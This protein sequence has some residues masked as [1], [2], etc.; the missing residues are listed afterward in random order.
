VSEP[1]CPFCV[2]PED[3]I[4]HRDDSV[5]GIWD[6]FPVSPGRALLVP[7][8]H[9]ANWFDATPTE[10]SELLAAV[11]VARYAIVEANAPDG[12]NI[13]I[14]VGPAA[15]QTVFHL[16]VHLIPRYEGD[17]ANPRGGVRYVIPAKANY[18][19]RRATSPAL[20]ASRT[21][22]GAEC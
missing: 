5:L 7:K 8:W 19:E 14:N 21:R 11:D 13:G 16:H 3:L 20:A 22:E 15:G 10:K 18:P 1:D 9:F 12:F 2:L 6:A 17:V 4:F